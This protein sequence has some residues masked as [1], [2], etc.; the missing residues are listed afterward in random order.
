MRWAGWLRNL[1]WAFL[2]AAIIVTPTVSAIEFIILAHR[3]TNVSE[4]AYL[5]TCGGLNE[6]RSEITG[7]IANTVQRSEKSTRATIAAPASTPQQRAVARQ[8]LAGLMKIEDQINTALAQK[9][10]QYPPIP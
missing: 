6:L 2:V 9:K 3:V 7:Y 4:T 10:C 1:A 8:N 5:E